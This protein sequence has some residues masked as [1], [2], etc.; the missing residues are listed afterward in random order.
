MAALEDVLDADEIDALE[1]AHETIRSIMDDNKDKLED[2]GIKGFFARV[3]GFFKG[4][5]K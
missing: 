3:G 4:L 1:E 5:F 2:A